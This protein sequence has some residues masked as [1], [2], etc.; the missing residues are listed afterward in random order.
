VRKLGYVAALDG[1]RGIAIFAVVL[2]HLFGVLPGGFFGVD[3]FFVLSGFLITTLLLEDGTLGRFYSR[4]VRRLLPALVVLLV[5]C[6]PLGWRLIAES[7]YLGNFFGAFGSGHI[8]DTGLGPLWSLA[9]EEQF[10]LF[11][12][13]LLLVLNGSRRRLIVG[14][15][16]AFVML[17]GYRAGLAYSGASMRRLYY[18]PDT[19]ADGLVLG[20]LAALVRPKIATVY[21]R[22]GLIVAVSFFFVGAWTTSWLAYG[23][24]IFEIASVLLIVAAADGLL[25]EL[26]FRVLVWLGLISYSL[27][28]WNQP[29]R[30]Y[31]QSRHPWMELAVAVGVAVLSFQFVEQPFRK[32]HVTSSRQDQRTVTRVEGRP[33]LSQEQPARAAALR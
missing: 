8:N 11:W 24:P 6:S 13:L 18:A 2:F 33:E 30:F 5:I 20:C 3:L 14:L 7:V 9:E 23:L 25:P 28:L 16:V 19:H 17:I 1:V 26:K 12:P 31:F 4:R 27:Y 10:Y 32:R 21:G 22:V 29:V 15:S